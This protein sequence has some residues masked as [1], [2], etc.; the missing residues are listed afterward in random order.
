MA[1]RASSGPIAVPQSTAPLLDPATGMVTA[2]WPAACSIAIPANAPTGYYLV[3]LSTAQAQTYAPL[4]VREAQP[5]APIVIA[6]PTD[7]YQAYNAWGG[8]SLYDN[9]R[10]DWPVAAHAYAVSFD[11]PYEQGDGAGQLFFSDR[12]LIT[13]VEAQGYDVGYLSDEDLD[14]DPTL[15]ARRRLLV[16]E[17][18][19]EYWTAGMRTAVEAA[20]GNGT[21][22]AFFGANDAYWQVRWS[23]SRR[24]LIGYKEYCASDPLAATAPEQASCQFR[25]LVQ[26]EP[27]NA[28]IGI[29]FGQWQ[30][31]AAPL[32]ISDGSSWLWSGSGAATDALIPGVFGFESDRRY[33][34][35]A[36]PAGLVEVGSAPME[37]HSGAVFSAQATLYTAASGATV[38]AAGS[39]DW[40]RML[41]DDAL[42]DTRVQQAT[43]N[44][45]TRLGTAGAAPASLAP[46]QLGPP[47]TLPS[48]RP[49]VTVSTWTSALTQPV[50]VVA[51]PNGD[52]LVADGNRIVRVTPSGAISVVA[53]GATAGDADGPAATAAFSGPRGLALRSD[54]GLYVADTSNHKIKLLLGGTVSTVAGSKEGFCDGSGAAA[55]FDDP[56][57]IDLHPSG[58]LLVA[59]AWNGRVRAMTSSGTVT[60]W[61]GD[62]TAASR[63]GAGV[64]AALNFP[65]AISVRADGS[66]VIVESESGRL[67][68]LANDLAHTVST[69]AGDGGRFGWNDGPPATAAVMETLGVASRA[70]GETVILDGATW[71]VRAIGASGAIDTLAGGVTA[72]LVDGSGASAGF[73]LPHAVAVAPDGSLLIADTGNRALRRITV[74]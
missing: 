21:S 12:S 10:S 45:F 67:R 63:D 59:D 24:S 15:L 69:F 44:L 23:A 1:A 73:Q 13:F 56:E 40:S 52:A 61:A 6:I 51:T 16:V 70:N 46:F 34:N 2:G 20:L 55:R 4:I 5:A 49:G 71:R 74:P 43:A 50:A 22:L 58:V 36:E 62:G 68:L 72:S 37:D 9:R 3:K 28:L 29:M 41:A 17:G 57:G 14:R 35:G 60:T 31:T 53:G 33:A 47:P 39:T 42:W 30:L 8:T 18:H 19:S 48:W 66:A 64:K 11:R 38:F 32:R 7:T 26:P 25:G 65:F 27:E 54:G